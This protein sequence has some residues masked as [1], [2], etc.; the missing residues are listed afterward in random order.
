MAKVSK[1]LAERFTKGVSKFKPILKSAHDRDL[2]ES[3]TVSIVKGILSDIMG[4]DKYTE[5]TSELAIRGTYCDLAIKVNE[6]IQF[7]IEV[8]AV[9][10]D[11]KEKH[12]RQA[13]NYGVNRG[14]QW[15]ILTNGVNW[16]LYRLKF[17][18]P[19]TFDRV[20]SFSF[21]D[22]NPRKGEDQEALYL[23]SSEGLRRSAREDYYEKIQSLNQYVVAAL[24]LTDPV[25]NAIRRDIRKLAPGL[26]VKTE[27][28]ERLLRHEIIRRGVIEGEDAER[29]SKQVR[30][31][32][33]KPKKKKTAKTA[34]P[35]KVAAE[36]S[37][38]QTLIN[39][40]NSIN[41]PSNHSNTT[42][43]TGRCGHLPGTTNPQQAVGYQMLNSTHTPTD[44]WTALR[45]GCLR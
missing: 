24:T 35:D 12:L 21:L 15:V 22:L 6:D 33:R 26:K 10:I 3:D 11:L 32:N 23:L 44:S 28:I 29:A 2:N 25:L 19:V 5:I 40:F 13:V 27:E 31:L 7:L 39:S 16:E 14:V 1:K 8:K 34:S 20:S 17:K 38:V 42:K 41:D 4:Y 36:T 9:G 18:K 45:S 37:V 43:Q 30:K